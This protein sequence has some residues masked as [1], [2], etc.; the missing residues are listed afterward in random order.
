MSPSLEL[1]PVFVH[2][3]AR[4]GSTY[5]F[6]VLRRNES[7]MCFNEAIDDK[8]DLMW[9]R[10][11]R[12]RQ[13]A[14]SGKARE[15]DV[16]HLFLDR[17]DNE[18]FFEAWDSVK[19][20]L[21]A[22]NLEM[23]DYFTLHGKLPDEILDY[24]ATLM[25]FARSRARRPVLCEVSSRGRAGAL[26][27]IFGGFHIAQ[28]RNPIS[29]FGSY[30]RGLVE[31]RTWD[32]LVGP[33]VELNTSIEHPLISI[34]P[35]K[36]RPP[37]FP[38][39][40]GS[41]AQFWATR[42]RYHAAFASPRPEAVADLFRWHMFSWTLANLA[43]VSYSDLAVDIDKLHDDADYRASIGS[44]IAREIGGASADFSDIRKF[45]RY[46]EFEAFD[47]TAVCDQVMSVIRSALADGRIE[48]GLRALAQQPPVLPAASAAE[49]V[50]GKITDSMSDMAASR[51]RTRMSNEEWQDIAGKNRRIWF[52]PV[53][54]QLG[55]MIHPLAFPLIRAARLRGVRI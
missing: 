48:A 50:L 31:G 46:F 47:V 3:S 53:L 15:W 41:R 2:A 30:V 6:N 13:I 23:Q 38:W 49:L 9:F 34:V 40:T 51:N 39:R 36:W 28:Y 16:N 20:S 43:A 25:K 1:N 44:A 32:F 21:P 22:V 55:K 52:S 24:L 19:H 37:F 14:R 17:D 10:E 54:R 18:E 29:Q 7:L 42:M 4:G 8:R 11:F 27:G 12:Q 33:V 35:E 5:F 26:R 45:G